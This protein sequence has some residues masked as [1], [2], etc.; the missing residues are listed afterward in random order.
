MLDSIRNRQISASFLPISYQDSRKREQQEFLISEEGFQL[1][2]QNYKTEE[3]Q[4][5]IK[6]YQILFNQANKQELDIIKPSNW[7][8]FGCPKYRMEE[9]FPGSIPG[10]VY[11]NALYYFAPQTGKIADIMAG[12]G[13]LRRVY[14]DRKRWQ[15]ELTFDLNVQLYD[16]HPREPFASRYGII[17]HDATIP[18]PECVNWI[19]FDPPYFGQSNHLYHGELAQTTDYQAYC[20]LL[21]QVIASAKASLIENGTLCVFV[22]PYIALNGHTVIYDTPLDIIRMATTQGFRVRQR[23]YV[24]RGEQQRSYSGKT[25]LKA[26]RLRQVFSDACELLVFIK[27]DRVYE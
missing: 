20:L 21:E 16:L 27:E 8:G 23:I 2:T 14:D 19:F 15:K 3:Q 1:L 24:N 12:S 10:E 13:M 22:T 26:K 25:N 4:R 17:Q 5:H 6:R 18:L 9:A 11:A 7:W